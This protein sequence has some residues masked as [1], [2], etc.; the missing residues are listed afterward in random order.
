[1]IILITINVVLWIW[2]ATYKGNSETP[3]S[4]TFTAY[5]ISLVIAG[6]LVMVYLQPVVF[7]LYIGIVP[8]VIHGLIYLHLIYKS[9]TIEHAK[10]I[11]KNYG[12]AQENTQ[13][14]S[15][16]L[17]PKTKYLHEQVAFLHEKKK[18]LHN[19]VKAAIG[20]K[21]VL[22]KLSPHK[23]LPHIQ[24]HI[25]QLKQVQDQLTT[26]EQAYDDF[27]QLVKSVYDQ[28]LISTTSHQA[29]L[30]E[31]GLYQAAIVLLQK[32]RRDCVEALNQL[33]P[34][35][36]K[37][38]SY[39]LHQQ[40]KQQKLKPSRKLKRLDKQASTL[41]Q[42][43]DLQNEEVFWKAYNAMIGLARNQQAHIQQT[44]K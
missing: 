15:I 35:V 17:S 25:K 16:E 34:T 33:R 27:A 30:K 43:F 20:Q 1:M 11:L 38:A 41:W 29:L 13:P 37:P 5:A 19:N 31:V 9:D 10:Q 18:R 22:L 8:I 6:A 21:K 14:D 44:S 2:Q 42:S 24:G 26:L 28:K 36:E 32:E 7:I 4:I 23:R 3:L 40:H 12:R 39:Y